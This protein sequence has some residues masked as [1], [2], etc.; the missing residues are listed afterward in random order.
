MQ[1][2]LEILRDQK[3]D[4]GA[5]LLQNDVGGHRRSVK[6]GADI[7]RGDAGLLDQ[8]LNAVEDPDRLI[9]GRR[10]CLQKTHC[11]GAFVEQ[12]QI[13]KR[14]A[15][16]DAEAATHVTYHPLRWPL[17]DVLRRSPDQSPLVVPP[18]GSALPQGP[19]RRGAYTGAFVW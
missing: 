5:L 12:K 8:L 1:D 9:T 19:R 17:R 2:L 14:P 7:G 4:F 6:Q 11:A 15:D 3:T 13:R 18:T 16:I 10:R